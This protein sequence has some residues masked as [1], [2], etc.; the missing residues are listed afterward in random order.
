[1]SYAIRHTI[2]WM[3]YFESA[4]VQRQLSLQDLFGLLMVLV[5]QLTSRGGSVKQAQPVEDFCHDRMAG[6]K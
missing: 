6:R 4:T 1:M 3:Y 5:S 2:L